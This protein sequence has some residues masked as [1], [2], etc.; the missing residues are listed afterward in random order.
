LTDIIKIK[1]Y[2]IN[3]GGVEYTFLCICVML[4]YELVVV[5]GW[6]SDTGHQRGGVDSW[7]MNGGAAFFPSNYSSMLA[8]SAAHFGSMSAPAFSIHHAR[9]PPMVRDCDWLCRYV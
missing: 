4:S 8:G 6:L 2:N 9:E 5:L 7:T 1:L 3:I